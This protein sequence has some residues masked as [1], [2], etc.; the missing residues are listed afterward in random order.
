[1]TVDPHN[2]FSLR[3]VAKPKLNFSISIGYS[4]GYR[5]YNFQMRHNWTPPVVNYIQYMLKITM[6]SD[7]LA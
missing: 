2:I 1:M 3:N 7:Y 4:M 5:L 6:V